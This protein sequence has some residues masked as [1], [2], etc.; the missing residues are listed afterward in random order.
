MHSIT[1]NSSTPKRVPKSGSYPEQQPKSNSGAGTNM[2]LKRISKFTCFECYEKFETD[3]LRKEHL[4]AMHLKYWTEKVC[5]PTTAVCFGSSCAFDHMIVNSEGDTWG[6]N[7]YTSEQ[8]ASGA[9][10]SFGL[11]RYE[12]PDLPCPTR[13]LREVCTRNHLWGRVRY[14]LKAKLRRKSAATMSSGVP[15]TAEDGVYSTPPALS[16]SDSLCEAPRKCKPSTDLVPRVLFEV[17]S[18]EKIEFG[19]NDNGI[20]DLVFGSAW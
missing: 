7:F 17:D 5:D 13:C 11:C 14:V 1:H 4:K 3:I 18:A 8:L 6:T 15:E 12:R 9:A 19:T 20:M 16:R 10:L 2:N